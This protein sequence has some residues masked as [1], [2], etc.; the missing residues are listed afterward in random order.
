VFE[1]EL[2]HPVE[3]V[4]RAVTEPEGLAHWFPE[5]GARGEVLELDPPKRLA[6]TWGTETLRLELKPQG[7]ATRLTLTHFLS[8]REQA[9]RDAA[10]WHVCLARLTDHLDGRDAD[11]PTSE[12]TPEWRELYE[13]YQARGLPAGAPVPG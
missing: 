12:A 5:P 11:A 1:R 6:L 13:G 3:A 8:T 9:A 10:G 4:W 2:R 7:D